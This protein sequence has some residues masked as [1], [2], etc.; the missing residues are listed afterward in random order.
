[1]SL[2]LNNLVTYARAALTK[3][4]RTAGA[5]AV[6]GYDSVT[7]KIVLPDGTTNSGSGAPIGS[8]SPTLVTPNIG[9]ATGTS[10]ALSGTGSLLSITNSNNAGRVT[11]TNS[12]TAFSSIAQTT[13]GVELVSGA[14]NTTNKYI[15]PLKFG[16]QDGDFTTTTPKYGA[17][18]TGY[19]TETYGSDTAGGMGLSFFTTANAPGASG[20]MVENMLLD[21]SGQLV[22][23]N[24]NLV[25]PK[26]SGV[27]IMVD[28]AAPTF[29]WRD[30]IG[31]VVVRGVGAADPSWNTYLTNI[32]QYQF[33][34]NDEIWFIH[35]IP[36]DYVPGTDL[37]FHVHWSH[38]SAAVTSGSVTWTIN[39]TYAKGHNQAAF[40]AT[41]TVTIT[42]SASTTQFQHMIAE[43][44][45]TTS[46]PGGTATLI[47]RALIE[48][49]G[50]L[51]TRVFLSANSMNGTP[52]PFL[53]FS[54]IHYQSTNLATKQKAPAFYT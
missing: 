43:A 15:T 37:Y 52:E 1:M 28:S 42:Q 21:N 20:N 22:V 10:L 30:I 36:H 17:A 53:H 48:P 7:G 8:T 14:A 24:S 40:P 49:D 50:M 34:V 19:A 45:I 9:V 33:T 54:D 44:V 6:L 32:R 12:S 35:H 47:D 41:K 38:A 13:R 27:G 5:T 25:V 11:I 4:Q 29:G 39:T 16:S 18:I 2:L 23:K 26:T 31:Q 46:T 3:L 51:M